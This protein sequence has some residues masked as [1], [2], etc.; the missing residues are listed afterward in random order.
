MR[1]FEY[2]LIKDLMRN[3]RMLLRQRQEVL[4]LMA[5]MAG[6][7][8]VFSQKELREFKTYRMKIWYVCE[9]VGVSVYV[10][11]CVRERMGIKAPMRSK[12]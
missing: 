11:V 10:C 1:H 7:K 3:H 8:K 2:I 12:S 9:C 5:R 4:N 6:I